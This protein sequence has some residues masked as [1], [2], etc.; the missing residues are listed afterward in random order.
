MTRSSGPET[1]RLKV[2]RGHTDLIALTGLRRALESCDAPGHL[3]AL[4]EALPAL[5]RDLNPEVS[6]ELAGIAMELAPYGPTFATDVMALEPALRRDWLRA[7]LCGGYDTRNISE[8]VLLQVCT[9]W[10]TTE[11]ASPDSLLA[12]LVDAADARLRALALE[13]IPDAVADLRI[14]S[15]EAFPLL[16][17]LCADIEPALRHDALVLLSCPW[18]RHVT[19]AAERERR[20]LIDAALHSPDLATVSSAIHSARHL[21]YAEEIRAALAD[22]DCTLDRSRLLM[23][24]LGDEAVESDIDLVLEV[25]S[26]EPLALAPTARDFL[27]A[28]HRRGTF[29]REQH[30]EELIGL[31]DADICWTGEEFWR[32]TF[33]IRHELLERLALEDADQ[34][35]WRRRAQILAASYGVNAHTLLAKL[36]TECTS[37]RIAT[38]LLHAAGAS[39]EFDAENAVLCWLPKLP[40]EA[41]AVLRCKGG[42][43]S[44]DALFALAMNL[45]TPRDLRKQVI[46]VLWSLSG[47]RE[48]LLSNLVAR[49][50]PLESGLLQS[51]RSHSRDTTIARLVRE[52]DFR[53]DASHT[54]SLFCESGDQGFSGDAI[55]LFRELYEDCV[56]KALQGDFTVKRVL[57]P[58]LEQRLFR[59]GRLLAQ[60]ERC[61]RRW[62]E[63]APET[64]RDFVISVVL[65]WLKETPSNTITVALLETLARHTPNGAVCRAIEGYWRHKHRGVQRAGIE[66]ILAAGE[67]ARGLELSICKL[68]NDGD[69][70][71][72]SQAL[73]AVATLEARWAEHL[74]VAC[75]ERP[76]M[77]VKKAAANALTVVGGP[78]SAPAIVHWL[79]RHDNSG[80][81]TA[82]HRA[83]ETA[84]GKGAAALLV[85]AL[86]DI[87]D[88]RGIELLYQGIS[89]RL[90]LGAALA[91]AKNAPTP[92]QLGLLNACLTGE[93]E[94]VGSSA[95]LLARRLHRAD[96]R[97]KTAPEDP[98]SEIRRDGFSYEAA[99]RLTQALGKESDARIVATVRSSIAEWVAALASSEVPVPSMVKLVLDAAR[100]PRGELSHTEQVD[101]LLDCIA[102]LGKSAPIASAITW[103][104]GISQRPIFGQRH[105]QRAITLVRDTTNSS[106]SEIGGLRRYR[107]LGNLSATRTPEDLCAALEA[108]RHRPDY[109]GESSSLLI[110]ALQIPA[111][112]LNEAY[113]TTALR[114]QALHWWQTD[115]PSRQLWLASVLDEGPLGIATAA[116]LREVPKARFVPYSR[117]HRETLRGL[118]SSPEEQERQRAANL[119]VEWG[120]S[121]AVETVLTTA[122]EG[123]ITPATHTL[124]PLAQA[125]EAWPTDDEQHQRALAFAPYLTPWQVRCFLPDWIAKWR[126]GSEG[127][128]ELFSVPRLQEALLPMARVAAEQGDLSLVTLLKPRASIAQQ[129]LIDS[130]KDT[131]PHAIAHLLGAAPLDRALESPVDPLDGA[132]F[133]ALV[134]LSA[135]PSVATGL[136]VRAIH[137]IATHGDIAIPVLFP[138]ATDRRTKI[139]SAALRALRTVASREQ[140]L[141][142]S[143]EALRMETRRDIVLRLMSSLGH[144]RFEPALPALLDRLTQSDYRVRQGAHAALRAWGAGAIPAIH[145]AS[146][147]ARP[148]RRPAYLALV[149]DLAE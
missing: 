67:G 116:P 26:R 4:A 105:R 82:L 21:G 148:D 140:T 130:L 29:V 121:E 102:L 35:A 44:H 81:R 79:S 24:A 14:S 58:D 99:L 57:L 45:D 135:D 28:A 12:S 11:L 49:L 64:G 27:L 114:S 72:L 3:R 71:I 39:P 141:E 94:L 40:E 129:T 52:S 25:L 131:A 76:E 65:D 83:L 10:N 138:L 112:R 96:L 46:D 143:L 53:L 70:R 98:T 145:H 59:Y 18:L 125:M 23:T 124:A 106:D 30:L 126:S 147:K 60:G 109:A 84:A 2:L 93:V 149:A 69:A 88:S 137:A 86:E 74:A 146:R 111:E 62:T 80:F 78:S 103:I 97:E 7:Y 15:K 1:Q 133:E 56:A 144:A 6:R 118:L 5:V 120:E 36:L 33:I 89:G 92:P 139:R 34:P 61:V 9:G 107:L 37:P 122:L 123:K 95:E 91:L 22:H 47:D 108:C 55:G 77:S 115:G 119:L 31:F 75:L 38:G 13:Y 136:A 68:A 132:N 32:I 43:A 48:T 42:Q 19:S 73:E 8:K 101:T 104:E 85:N 51:G 117:E 87:T 54:F 17:R 128:I 50:G 16:K 90:A 127:M 113:E 20:A 100:E 142:A 63:D 66:A 110:E 41:L 134:T